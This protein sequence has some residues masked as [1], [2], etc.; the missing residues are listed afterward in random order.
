MIA[1]ELRACISHAASCPFRRCEN[2]L[3]Y[4]NHTALNFHFSPP[5]LSLPYLSCLHL[6]YSPHTF[7]LNSYIFFFNLK[8]HFYTYLCSDLQQSSFLCGGPSF[9]LGIIFLLRE[10]LPL[11]FLSVGRRWILSAETD[12]E[13]FCFTFIFFFFFTFIFERFFSP[14]FRLIL[15]LASVL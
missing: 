6:S 4:K 1:S 7:T 14:N 9:Q 8:K 2:H 5:A 12:W 15:V 3:V 10:G 13:S 11:A